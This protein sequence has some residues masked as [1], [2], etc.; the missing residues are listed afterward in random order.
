MREMRL[1]KFRRGVIG[2]IEAQFEYR[3]TDV[4][5]EKYKKLAEVA[6]R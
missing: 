2:C 4:M 6:R 3:D 5:V 1:W